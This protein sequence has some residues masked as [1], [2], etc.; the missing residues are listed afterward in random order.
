MWVN[1][2]C[3]IQSELS[4]KERKPTLY[5]SICIWI[6]EKWYRGAYLQER[7]RDIDLEIASVDTVG[8]GA[9]EMNGESSI[10]IYTLP[11]LK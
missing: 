8:E 11:C 6:L 7:N 10:D 3:V 9:G 4:Q 5:I 2:D 1:T